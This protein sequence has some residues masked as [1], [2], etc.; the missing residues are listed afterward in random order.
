MSISSLYRL[1]LPIDLYCYP[2]LTRCLSKLYSAHTLP[3]RY[4]CNRF[5]DRYGLLDSRSGIGTI[6][7]IA[8][9]CFEKIIDLIIILF[10]SLHDGITSS[11]H[12]L[13][14]YKY[15]RHEAFL[16]SHFR[17]QFFYSRYVYATSTAIIIITRERYEPTFEPTGLF[18]LCASKREH[19][20]T[21]YPY[22]IPSFP[23]YNQKETP[24][25]SPF[26]VSRHT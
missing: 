11:S 26:P 1:R 20:H 6:N 23:I 13:P 15:I 7:I 14:S 18:P 8:C 3:T 4:E 2:R 25:L 9:S 12:S 5:I 19:F 22:N 24:T 10:A 16:I 21:T 17:F